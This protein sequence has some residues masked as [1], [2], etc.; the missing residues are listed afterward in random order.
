MQDAAGTK[1]GKSDLYV[2]RYTKLNS[3]CTKINLEKRMLYRSIP[4]YT[5]LPNAI[6]SYTELYPSWYVQIYTEY[7]SVYN[8]AK[9]M[10]QV[11][12]GI[13]WYILFGQ[14]YPELYMS[15]VGTLLNSV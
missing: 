13:T 10:Y 4:R 3:V 9:S 7:S 6:P 11:I 14:S 5:Q 15:M 1:N 8:L 12:L 2:P